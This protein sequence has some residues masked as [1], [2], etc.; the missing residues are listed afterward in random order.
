MA[1]SAQE[2]RDEREVFGLIVVLSLVITRLVTV[3]RRFPFLLDDVIYFKRELLPIKF[4]FLFIYLFFYL[5]CLS[6]LPVHSI[7]LL[8]LVLFLSPH[9]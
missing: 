5:F 9:G 2:S 4:N 1:G 3:G 7:Q 6:F 8:P